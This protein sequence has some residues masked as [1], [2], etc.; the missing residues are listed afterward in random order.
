[1]GRQEVAPRPD[2]RVSW[3]QRAGN[4][5]RRHRT[6]DTEPIV[7]SATTAAGRSPNGAPGGADSASIG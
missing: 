6:H 4:S 7:D 1:M 2:S 3:R 5:R